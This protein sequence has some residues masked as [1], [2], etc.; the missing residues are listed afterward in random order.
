[1]IQGTVFDQSGVVMHGPASRPRN[2][3]TN[4]TKSQNTDA[5]GRFIFLALPP[6]RYTLTISHSGFSTVVQEN[7]SLTVGQ[8]I[9][10]S[11]QPQGFRDGGTHRGDGNAAHRHHRQRDPPPP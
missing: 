6:G 9:N 3:D 11:F 10:L 7:L 2:P 4:F 5:N 8:A 1:M